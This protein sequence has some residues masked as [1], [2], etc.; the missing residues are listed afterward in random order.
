[1]SAFK[2]TNR[3]VVERCQALFASSKA[4]YNF[5]N[6]NREKSRRQLEEHI[7]ANVPSVAY[8]SDFQ[9]AGKST[10][11]E[12][13]VNTFGWKS[14]R[15]AMVRAR[16]VSVARLAE[17]FTNFGILIVDD[18][19]IRT[20][21]N[22]I[23]DGLKLVRL[24]GE[25][26]RCPIVVCGDFTIRNEEV[27]S[28]F[29]LPTQRDVIME[30][31]DREFFLEALT[32]RLQFLFKDHKPEVSDAVGELFD[33]VLLECLVPK[34][35]VPISTFREILT[36]AAGLSQEIEPSD[37]VFR[38]TKEHAELYCQ[39]HPLDGPSEKQWLFLNSWLK[40]FV[41]VTHPHGRGM[42]PFDA[43]QVLANTA[44][45]GIDSAE[46]LE[47]LVLEPLCAAGYLHALGVPGVQ[48]A[49]F[50]RYPGPYVPRPIFLLHAYAGSEDWPFGN[51]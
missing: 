42:K 22:K 26:N 41:T 38:L 32:Q 39:G 27:R 44:I 11:L 12:M 6:A 47:D 37:E 2:L 49:E 43:E 9:G 18:A 33:E 40:P 5:P 21:W 7:K 14:E 4:V 23:V 34:S 10:L 29:D 30:P 45:V 1:M 50:N 31:V 36:L 20:S 19:D 25:S 13:V 46:Q 17:D 8:I 51:G 48:D 15:T 16:D 28:I 24:F 3:L 35:L